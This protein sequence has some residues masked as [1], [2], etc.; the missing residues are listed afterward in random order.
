MVAAT[1]GV[2]VRRE[3]ERHGRN[4]PGDVADVVG[5]SAR[6]WLRRRAGEL[7]LTAR[8]RFAGKRPPSELG[9]FVALADLL[10]SPRVQGENTPFKVYTFLASGRPLLATRIPTH[11]QLLDDE[12]AWLVEPTPHALAEGVARAL[13]EPDASAERARAGRAL[14]EREY[15][16]ARFEEKVAAAYADVAKAVRS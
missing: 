2:E 15:S 8:C 12:L 5:A 6:A 4:V 16:Q 3:T 10:V 11:T 14:V 1:A 7:G 9:R 13:A